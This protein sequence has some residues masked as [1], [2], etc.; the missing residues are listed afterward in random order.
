MIAVDARHEPRV[1][2]C[3][4]STHRLEP[5]R[6]VRIA[7]AEL[8]QRGVD[9]F[10][11]GVPLPGE[12][13]QTEQL[14]G[15]PRAHARLLAQPQR[16]LQVRDGARVARQHL[17]PPELV[18]QRRAIRRSRR[19]RERP[20]EI[21][22]RGLR[23]TPRKRRGSRDPQLLHN[24]RLAEGLAR[25]QVRRDLLGV[26][27]LGGEQA[28][29]TRMRQRPCGRREI[30][31]DGGPHDRVDELQRQLR[32]QDLDRGQRVSGLRCGPLVQLREQRRVAQMRPAAEHR[33]R[34][35]QTARP[36]RQPRE[37]QH[38]RV[39]YRARPELADA[40]GRG[41]RRGDPVTRERAE[42]LAREERIASRGVVAGEHEP[43]IRAAEAGPNQL[44]DRADGQRRRAPARG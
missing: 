27:V 34:L 12:Q 41:R 39:P 33:D 31:I 10:E 24:P 35:R 20:L 25:K 6:R 18:E 19:L 14:V 26:G 32:L 22:S 21:R 5:R 13:Q 16:L 43:L 8:A 38:D 44:A 11:R 9:E 15:D 42:Q 7:V 36:F 4:R 1:D 23:G 28:R 40:G 3:H 17:G 30:V 37:P 29:G 2:A